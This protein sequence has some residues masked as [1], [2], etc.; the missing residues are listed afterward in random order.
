MLLRLFFTVLPLGIFADVA[1][2]GPAYA[3]SLG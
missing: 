3:G 1:D 2:A